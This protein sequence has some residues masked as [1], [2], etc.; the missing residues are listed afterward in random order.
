M[1]RFPVLIL[2]FL[3]SLS[4]R[5][6]TYQFTNYGLDEGMFD[7][8]T[9]TINQDRQ[10]FLWIG[11]GDGLCRFDGQVFE[12][13]F[14]GD[15]IPSSI[16]HASLLDSQGRL[17]FGHENG[18]LSV[19]QNGAFRLLEPG[20]DH[21]SKVTAI[22]EDEAGNILDPGE[23]GELVVQGRQVGQG[24]LLDGG[25][26]EIFAPGGRMFTG[27]VGYK[28]EEGWRNYHCYR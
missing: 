16:A 25:E 14:K 17:W 21:R 27:D 6:Q 3:L 19:Y 28:D 15:S 26:V 7:K 22:Q 11:T 18:L 23:E 20:A 10:G 12:N 9:Y 8:F 13:E 5:A 24:Y 4:G 1:K 2:F